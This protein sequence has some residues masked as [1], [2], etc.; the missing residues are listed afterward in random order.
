MVPKRRVD[1][2]NSD[3]VAHNEVLVRWKAS[4]MFIDRIR[5][6]TD[7]AKSSWESLGW[8][9]SGFI[10]NRKNTFHL[11]LVL[12]EF[13]EV[14]KVLLGDSE[15]RLVVWNH[16]RQCLLV[17]RADLPVWRNGR[18][19]SARLVRHFSKY[20]M[21]GVKNTIRRLQAWSTIEWSTSCRQRLR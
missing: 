14:H 9:D 20:T 4:W 11:K 7:V 13:Q 17:N 18:Y 5:T 19:D 21:G 16:Q 12:G 2:R 10:E 15:H 6:E 3:F 8:I 1:E